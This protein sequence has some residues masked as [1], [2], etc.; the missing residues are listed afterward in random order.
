[1][2]LH[3]PCCHCF[4]S[5][6]AQMCQLLWLVLLRALVGQRLGQEPQCWPSLIA[7]TAT[8]HWCS[9]KSTSSKLACWFK[10]A[11]GTHFWLCCTSLVPS[12]HYILRVV[13]CG[14]LS[15]WV[16]LINP[17]RNQTLHF[18]G[19]VFSGCA[20]K[21]NQSKARGWVPSRKKPFFLN[22]CKSP[23]SMAY[24]FHMYCLAPFRT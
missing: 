1:M 9:S 12:K 21:A 4:N 14:P 23:P 20:S 7:A 2:T 22:H 6:E 5:Q 24:E 17:Q 15:A 8:L 11:W 3:P 19:S 13:L 16:Q 10:K 18:A